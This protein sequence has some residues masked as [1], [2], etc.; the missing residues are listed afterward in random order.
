MGEQILSETDMA[1]GL[2]SVALRCFNVAGAALDGKNGQRTKGA[3]H[4]IKIACEVACGVRDSLE[5]FGTDYETPDGTG[6]RD[7]IHV[8]DLADIQ[9]L[10]LKY[11]EKG[12]ASQ[13]LNCG[14]GQGYSVKQ[15]ISAVEKISGKSI[16][17]KHGPRRLGDAASLIADNTKI[18]ELFAWTPKH[19]NL[20]SICRSALE[21]EKNLR[22][23]S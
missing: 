20:E 19:N 18:R 13:I 11:L 8:E 23:G 16:Q 17:V 3:T 22:E 15:V 2:K 4:L 7:Y 14:Y 6:V 9:V 12:G 5:I 1:H 10:A 21:W